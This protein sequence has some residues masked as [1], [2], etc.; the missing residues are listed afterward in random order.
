[1]K[2]NNKTKKYL[3]IHNTLIILFFLVFV[4]VPQFD[5]HI[6][7]R[8]SEREEK[9]II[10][11]SIKFPVAD[12]I[13][14]HIHILRIGKKIKISFNIFFSLDVIL[15]ICVDERWIE[16]LRNL[17]SGQNKRTQLID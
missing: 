10:C 3:P 16:V 9:E 13:N 1:M 5:S 2:I 12:I 17:G 11:I 7:V 8:K 14:G 6:S 4:D 15:C